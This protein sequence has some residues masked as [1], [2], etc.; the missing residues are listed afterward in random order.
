MSAFEGKTLQ[1]SVYAEN[2]VR[3]RISS[4]FEPTLLE[5]IETI[6]PK[7]E[8]PV[9]YNDYKEYWILDKE[10]KKIYFNDVESFK[11]AI[12]IYKEREN[13]EKIEN[14]IEEDNKEENEY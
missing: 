3:I 4:D 9:Y 11:N 14:V 1:L 5:Q 12:E 6:D 2:I 10:D 7:N 13:K 8:Y